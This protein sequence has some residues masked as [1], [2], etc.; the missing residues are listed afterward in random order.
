VVILRKGK[1][2]Q[3]LSEST[4]YITTV[5]AVDKPNDMTREITKLRE[6]ND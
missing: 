3:R 1:H 4:V 2:L 6:I 5:K